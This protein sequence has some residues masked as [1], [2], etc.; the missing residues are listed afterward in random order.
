MLFTTGYLTKRGKSEGKV[1]QLV[2]PN[3]EIKEIFIE[4]ILEWFQEEAYKGTT[5]LDAFCAAFPK[6]DARAMEEY[7]NFY[8]RRTISIRDTSVK[9]KTSTTEYC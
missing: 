7:F 4:H 1:F 8:L 2:I 9:K 5:K 6:A 3:L